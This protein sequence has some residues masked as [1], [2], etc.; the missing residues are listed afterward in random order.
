MNSYDTLKLIHISCVAASFVLFQCRMLWSLRNSPLNISRWARVLPHIIDTALLI[1]G[2]ALAVQLR[3]NPIHTPWLAAK[4]V[5]LMCYI[6][7]GSI[8]YKHLN[9]LRKKFIAWFFTD[10]LFIAIAWIALH[11]TML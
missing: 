4:L 10:L 6:G 3:L 7:A 8:A 1:T 5:L 11:K 2:T 9:H